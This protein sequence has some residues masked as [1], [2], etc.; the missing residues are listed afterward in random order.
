MGAFVALG[1]PGAR[2]PAAASAAVAAP[3]AAASPAATER[4]RRDYDGYSTG[5]DSLDGGPLAAWLGLDK[6]RAE[7]VG[8]ARGRVLE[9]GVG[10]G[11]NL[12]FY[13]RVDSVDA[14]DLSPGMLRE[15]RAKADGLGLLAGG[16]GFS[17]RFH[18]RDV[19]RLEGFAD[20]SFDSVVDT[21]SLWC[22]FVIVRL[23]GCRTN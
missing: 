21:F 13:R 3:A 5:Y 2:R 20:G 18:E 12:P 4:L 19:A 8:R 6:A 11:L 10:T 15:A 7:L 1:A 16:G 23:D 17:V 9:A 14:I 22:V